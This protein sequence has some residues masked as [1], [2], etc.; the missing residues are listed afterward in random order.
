MPLGLAAGLGSIEAR[1]SSTVVAGDGA[2]PRSRASRSRTC[3]ARL[4]RLVLAGADDVLG[5]HRG[6]AAGGEREG[7]PRPD[8][9]RPGRE[10]GRGLAQHRLCQRGGGGVELA[11]YLGGEAS[12]RVRCGLDSDREGLQA[13]LVRE[14]CEEPAEQRDPGVHRVGVD[15]LGALRL[16][17]Q[18]H[19]VVA[20]RGDRHEREPLPHPGLGEEDLRAGEQPRQ[21]GGA[22]R[23]RGDGAG[24]VEVLALALAAPPRHAGGGGLPNVAPGAVLLGNPAD[25]S[26]NSRATT[27]AGGQPRPSCVRTVVARPTKMSTV[28]SEPSPNRPGER[29]TA[30]LP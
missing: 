19:C 4:V 12:A 11:G 26:R 17:A 8:R 1:S 25:A 20:G 15:E 24:E 3:C 18:H 5:L 21:A 10:G 2:V 14:V 27:P 16:A 13:G 6:G 22:E 29:G 9:R 28:P 30:Q 7:D 23:D